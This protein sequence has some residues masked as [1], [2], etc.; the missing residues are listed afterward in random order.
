MF[1]Y[2][3]QPKVV[4]SLAVTLSAGKLRP[5]GLSR[6]DTSRCELRATK[7]RR[8][9][10][11]NMAIHDKKVQRD[12]AGACGQSTRRNHPQYENGTLVNIPFNADVM[13]SRP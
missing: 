10:L 12:F 7:I 3:Y 5:L 13:G 9:T 11:Y 6:T 4:V 2:A 8:G 1:V